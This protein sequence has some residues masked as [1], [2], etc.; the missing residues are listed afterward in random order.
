M[1]PQRQRPI[2]SHP[3]MVR[4]PSKKLRKVLQKELQA[5]VQDKDFGVANLQMV[6]RFAD[7]ARQL[8]ATL[9]PRINMVTPGCDVE[10]GYQ[11]GMG[12]PNPVMTMSSSNETYGASLSRELIAAVGKMHDKPRDPVELV[13]AIGVARDKGLNTLADKLE[14]ELLRSEPQ[15]TQPEEPDEPVKEAS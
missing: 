6:Q 2:P 12:I 15:Q 4:K 14:A 3:D 10:F 13:N 7:H 5:I 11:M 1:Q 9:D 8:L